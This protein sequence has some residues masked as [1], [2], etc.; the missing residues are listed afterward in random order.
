MNNLIN[1]N[2]SLNNIISDL[3]GFKSISE[4]ENLSMINY[5]SEFLKRFGV[6]PKIVA[7][8]DNRANLY[9]MIGPKKEGGIM[10]SGH[11]DVVPTEGQDW[12]SDPFKLMIKNNRLYGRGTCDMK[13]FIG[14]ILFLIPKI[15]NLKLKRPIHLMFSFDEEIGCVGIQKAIPFLKSLKIKPSTCIVGE[16]TEMKV[17]NQHKGKKNFLVKFNGIEAHSSQI[18]KGVNTIKYASEL[19]SFLNFIQNELKNKID[20]SFT[21]PYATIN[22][23]KIKGGIALNIIPKECEIEFEIRDLPDSDSKK[24]IDQIKD[25]LFNNLEKKMKLENKK[26]SI[27]FLITN[28]FPPLIT[29]QDKEII[30]LTLNLTK[31]NKTESVS[32][33]TEA[34]VFNNLNID[35]IVCGPGNINQ[36]HKPDEFIEIKQIKKCKIFIENLLESL[37]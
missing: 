6:K 30:N 4:H 9:A 3:I 26:C 19:I 14:I 17:I 7:K 37:C 31:S 20:E 23:G 29:S 22:I 1:K 15:K 21:P 5:I 27:N 16:P 12:S 11:T 25:Y 36:A 28:N 2:L 10:L 33:G 24:I 8:E 34:G 35:T 32:F 18:D 13:S